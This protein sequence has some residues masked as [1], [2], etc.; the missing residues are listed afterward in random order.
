MKVIATASTLGQAFKNAGRVREI[1]AVFV[2]HGYAD[3]LHRMQLGRFIP[4]KYSEVQRYKHLPAA[5]RL[6]LSFEELG[7]TFIK[8]GQL[9]ASR[10]DLIPEP[11][12]EEF[13]KLQDNV[14]NV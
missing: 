12:V 1:L 10:P 2:R 7:T 4:Q 6:R 11:F 5:E 14:S 13:E 8:L 3:L 9:L